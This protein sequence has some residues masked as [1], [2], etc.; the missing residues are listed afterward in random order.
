M[1][2]HAGCRGIVNFPRVA[3]YLYET[4]GYLR[5]SAGDVYEKLGGAKQSTRKRQAARV[6]DAGAIPAASTKRRPGR[7]GRQGYA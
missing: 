5:C 7:Q 2:K 1:L 6:R 4:A 3:G